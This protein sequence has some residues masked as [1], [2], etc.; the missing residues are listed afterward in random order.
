MVSSLE[1]QYRRGEITEETQLR[2][3]GL[4][5]FMTAGQEG[6][7]VRGAGAADQ[8]SWGEESQGR[9]HRQKCYETRII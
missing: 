5:Y 1:D 4:V 2:C 9:V 8:V 6:V 7:K 3:C